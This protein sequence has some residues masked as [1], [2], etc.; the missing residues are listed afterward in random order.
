MDTIEVKTLFFSDDG[1]IPNHPSLPVLIYPGVLRDKAGQTESI[2]NRNNW[3]NSWQNGVFDYH[4]YHSNAHEVLGVMKGSA[5]LMLGGENGKQIEVREGDVLVLPA[6]TGHKRLDASSTFKVAGAYPGGMDYTTK[7][8]KSSERPHVLKEIQNVPL[9][10][11][12][13]VF[14]KD[15]PLMDHWNIR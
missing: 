13:P 4:H 11:N 9:P 12:D 5:T 2:F 15:G 1:N 8:G 3:G 10:D 6:G 7:T 14:G